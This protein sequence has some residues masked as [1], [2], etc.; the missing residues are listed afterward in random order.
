MATVKTAISIDKSLLAAVDLL[1]QQLNSSRSE[2]FRQSASEFLRKRLKHNLLKQLND[3]YAEEPDAREH[4][5]LKLVKRKQRK[6][7]EQW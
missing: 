4:Q 7:T 5:M 6:L 1:A 2:I 3:A